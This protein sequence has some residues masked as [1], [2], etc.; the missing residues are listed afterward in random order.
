MSFEVEENETV[1]PKGGV[2][3]RPAGTPMTGVPCPAWRGPRTISVA[4][5]VASGALVLSWGGRPVGLPAP[6]DVDRGAGGRSTGTITAVL[7]AGVLA[8]LLIA[9]A[10]GLLYALDQKSLLP[11]EGVHE[12][13]QQSTEIGRGH[14]ATTD[15]PSL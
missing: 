12:A 7:V 5:L 1:T 15:T 13:P 8:V 2:P 11:D 4:A 14:I 3:S 9:P 6:R 10:F